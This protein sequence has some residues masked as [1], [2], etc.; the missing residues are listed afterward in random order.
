[1]N[2]VVRVAGNMLIDLKDFALVRTQEDGS[3]RHALLAISPNPEIEAQCLALCK[4]DYSP[5][6]C[7][8]EI[9]EAMSVGRPLA[10]VSKWTEQPPP[11]ALTG[12]DQAP[13]P[14]QVDLAARPVIARLTLADLVGLS[15]REQ[16]AQ[17]KGCYIEDV[18]SNAVQVAVIG[19]RLK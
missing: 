2:I 15:G 14:M 13:R 6:A 1:M 7:M 10:D 16:L 4:R 12:K 19:R 17:L 3:G 8:T 9:A 11:E 18:Q 5:A